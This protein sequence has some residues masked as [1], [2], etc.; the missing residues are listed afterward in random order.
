MVP[1]EKPALRFAVRARQFLQRLSSPKK[2][3][4]LHSSPAW[5]VLH[6]RRGLLPPALHFADA[7]VRRCIRNL[8]HDSAPGPDALRLAIIKRLGHCPGGAEQGGSALQE[9]TRFVSKC[10]D[11]D[12][13]EDIRSLFGGATLLGLPK[14]Q[15][16]SLRPI[17]IGVLLRRFISRVLVQRVSR[18]AGLLQYF[19]PHQFSVGVKNGTESITH[20]AREVSDRLATGAFVLI[21]VDATNAFNSIVRQRILKQITTRVPGLARFVSAI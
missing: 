12:R 1:W 19:L 18:D 8:P 4:S 10:V 3:H 17:A 21:K 11:G 15:S 6:L 16:E 13:P 5:T 7:E 2:L 20:G 14:P 9:I